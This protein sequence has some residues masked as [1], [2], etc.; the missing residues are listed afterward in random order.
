MKGLGF[1]IPTDRK[2][3]HDNDLKEENLYYRTFTNR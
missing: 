2:F 1:V 3:N